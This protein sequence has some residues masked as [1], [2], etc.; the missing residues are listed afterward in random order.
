M[1]EFTGTAD[2]DEFIGTDEEADTFYFTSDTLSYA[3]RARGGGGVG[4]PPD[5]LVL[6]DSNQSDAS[7]SISLGRNMPGVERVILHEQGNKIYALSSMAIFG[8]GDG[9]DRIF[10]DRKIHQ[11]VTVHARGGDDTVYSGGGKDHIFGE[12]G[13]DTIYGTDRYDPMTHDGSAYSKTAVYDGGAGD[14]FL[15][16]GGFD[17]FYHGTGVT[18]LGGT[19][20]DTIVA[21]YRNTIDGGAGIDLIVGYHAANELV[22]DNVEGIAFMLSSNSE[23]GSSTG[24]AADF[25][26][27]RYLRGDASIGITDEGT[28][29]L[30]HLVELPHSIRIYGGGIV[31]GTRTVAN[32]INGSMGNNQLTGGLKADTINGGW[33]DDTL[34]GG[35]GS[36]TLDGGGDFVQDGNS[37]SDALF[38]GLGNDTFLNLRGTASAWGEAGNDSFTVYSN[39]EGSIRA[40][41]GEGDDRFSLGSSV[42]FD[43]TIDGGSG[44]DTVDLYMSAIHNGSFSDI[45]VY[46]IFLPGGSID[47]SHCAPVPDSA[48]IIRNMTNLGPVSIRGL[49]G[50]DQMFGRSNRDTLD[51]AGG[52]DRLYGGKDADVFAFSSLPRD[53]GEYDRIVD[54]KPGIDKIGLDRDIFD[55]PAGTTLPSA[56]FHIGTK[57]E[58]PGQHLIYNDANGVLRYDPDGSG[59]QAAI[60]FATLL[61]HP[62]LHAADFRILG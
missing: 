29:D 48:T 57:A 41:G 43:G 10:T 3:D 28:L 2:T 55:L 13:N 31:R 39:S 44:H 5:R 21:S 9:V 15:D 8:T 24:T 52:S 16:A 51:G 50:D 17:D 11:R 18:L 53:V 14:D 22:L 36:D 19:G 12:G 7:N 56:Y 23:S 40:F 62:D 1:A 46:N 35:E 25:A 30:S 59:A 58:T 47:L 26:F 33:G 32:E 49:W 37:G 61:K 4:F 6:T 38:G 34:R 20:N 54:F 42:A 45:E 60:H 27:V